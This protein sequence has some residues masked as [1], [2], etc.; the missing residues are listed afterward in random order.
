MEINKINGHTRILGAPSNWDQSKEECVGL[1]VID[2]ASENGPVMISEWQPESEDLKLLNIGMPLHLWVFGDVHPV[3]SISV[4]QPTQEVIDKAALE[5]PFNPDWDLK[6]AHRESMTEAGVLIG[7]LEEKVK[8]L[9]AERDTLQYQILNESTEADLK[10]QSMQSDHQIAL[11][12]EEEKGYARGLVDG[13]TLIE[14]QDPW[15]PIET[16]IEFDEIIVTGYCFGDLEKGRFYTKAKRYGDEF[17]STNEDGQEEEIGF[18][19]HW[20][21]TPGSHHTKTFSKAIPTTQE[22][23]KSIGKL[24]MTLHTNTAHL[25]KTITDLIACDAYA[26]TFQTLGQ[27]RT[28][29]KKEIEKALA[30]NINIDNN[31]A[32]MPRTL[33]AENCGKAGLMGEFF[34][35]VQVACSQCDNEGTLS[36]GTECADCEGTGVLFE[37]HTI[38]WT[39]IKA[40]YVKAVEVCEVKQIA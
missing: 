33:T 16:A 39:T 1:P 23:S 36:D 21:Y 30:D 31:V 25:R 2:S 3:V 26:I 28:A 32:L 5:E 22:P 15:E 12:R 34:V 6:K 37:P 14:V 27:Y 35:S 13:R 29:L 11:R 7:N 4:G 9:T 10:M 24:T 17:Y 20:I 38:D 19:T 18:L 8:A 40:I